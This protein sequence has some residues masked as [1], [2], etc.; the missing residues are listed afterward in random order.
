VVKEAMLW[1]IVV[2][3]LKK[4]THRGKVKNLKKFGVILPFKFIVE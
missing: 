2:V 3:K 1:N 4:V